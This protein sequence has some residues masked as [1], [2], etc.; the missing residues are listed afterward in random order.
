MLVVRTVEHSFGYKTGFPFLKY[1]KYLAPPY[2]TDLDIWNV[3]EENP[4]PVAESHVEL[5]I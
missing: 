5:H 1:P 2:K 4:T 3:L